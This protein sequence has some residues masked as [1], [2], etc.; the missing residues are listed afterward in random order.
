MLRP[1]VLE[2][3]AGEEMGAQRLVTQTLGQEQQGTGALATLG[4]G[5]G[6][7]LSPNAPP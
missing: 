1:L 4:R 3:F 2:P 6:R 7:A 5:S